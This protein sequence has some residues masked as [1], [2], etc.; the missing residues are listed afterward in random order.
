[1]EL[2]FGAF[3]SI[4][5]SI[6]VAYDD[7]VD[8]YIASVKTGAAILNGAK[9]AANDLTVVNFITIE[10]VADATSLL[11]ADFATIIA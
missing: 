6:V 3:A 8:S 10:G 9:A 5:D 7:G 2:V 11:A 1:M 4:G